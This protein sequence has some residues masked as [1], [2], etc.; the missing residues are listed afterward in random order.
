MVAV[1]ATDRLSVVCLRLPASI[2]RKT[3]EEHKANTWGQ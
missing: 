3:E 1:I 2:G